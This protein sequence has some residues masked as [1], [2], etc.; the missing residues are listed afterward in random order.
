MKIFKSTVWRGMTIATTILTVFS[1]T[2]T[3]V[4]KE[5]AS[6]INDTLKVQTSMVVSNEEG[7]DI[8]TQYFKSA[9]SNLSDLYKAKVELM[10]EIGQEG[11]VLLKNDGNV[12]PILSG[13]VTILGEEN[14]MYA[15]DHGGGSFGEYNIKNKVSLSSALSNAGLTVNNDLSDLKGGIAIIVIG[16]SAGEGNDMPI[17]ELALTDTEKEL[18]KKVK[19]SGAEKIIL[20]SSGDYSIEMSEQV[21]DSAIDGIIRFGNAGYRGIYGL[22]DVIT[23]K[24]A[25]SGKLVE[26]MATSSTSSPA[27]QNFGNFSYTNGSSIM[28]SQAKSYV[29]YMEGIYDDYKYYE[30]R[31]EDCVLGQGNASLAVGAYASKDAW[32]YSNEVLYSFGYGLSY[33]HFTKQIID[34]PV[35]NKSENTATISVKVTNDSD[36][37]AGKEVVQIY[38]QSPYTDYDKENLVEKSSVQLLGFEKTGV[39]QPGASETVDVIVNLQWLASYDYT[40]AK[41][42]ILDAGD[43][44]LSVGNGAHEALNNILASK[45]KTIADGMDVKGDASLTYKWH[46]DKLDTT[47]YSKSLYTG[48]EITN[49]FADADVN[50]WLDTDVKY[51]TRNHW[52]TTFPQPL[53]ITAASDMISSLNDLKKYENQTWNDTAKR[54]KSREVNYVDNE[55]GSNIEKQTDVMALMGKPYDDEGWNVVLDKLTIYEISKIISNGRT[56]IQA[57]PSIG[58]PE[59]L[60]SDSPVGLDKYYI[61]SAID[62]ATGKKT[63]AGDSYMSSDGITNNEADLTKLEAAMYSSEPVLAATFNKDL[64]LHQGEMMGED[65]LYTG[66]AFTWGLGANIHRTPY[67]GRAS[68]YYSAD[69]ILTALIGTATTQGAK[70]KGHVLVAKHFAVNDQEQNRIGVATFLNEQTLRENYLRAFEGILTY[71]GSQGIMASYNRIGII[72]TASEYDLMTTVLRNEWGSKCYV[73]TDLNGP[74]SGLYDGNAMIAA[75]TSTI[76]NNGAYDS[77][78]KGSAYVNST[79]SPKNIKNDPIL[80][81]TARESV[82]RILYNFVN[83]MA[84]NG[85]SNNSYIVTLTPWYQT[86]LNILDI[87]FCIIAVGSGILYLLSVNLKRKRDKEL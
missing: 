40:N 26:T 9:Y 65:G 59:C 79:L 62:K 24:V 20:L 30:T 14:L 15:T 6:I 87:F 19:Q 42:Y 7:K 72:G 44:Y 22:V 78:K 60:G 1:I 37:I 61:Y 39:L 49:S 31:Y 53:S 57:S 4:T 45:G 43:Y 85:Y 34:E 63:K 51:L 41:T 75:G 68:E 5:F 77:T 56:S 52:D 82:H 29:A 46:V 50:Y 70:S 69:P 18:I 23:G 81:T 64:A 11:V 10:R 76:L 32:N 21:K 27:I 35:F 25:P 36:S 3:S 48:Q 86:T 47:T 58:F 67:G 12:L 71:G 2:L 74:T 33:A 16:R 66:M 83:S 13:K 84:M 80:L 17:G 54:L 38:G 55:T 8:D 28:A 73:I